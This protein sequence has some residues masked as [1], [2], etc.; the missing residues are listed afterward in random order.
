M[1]N[2]VESKSLLKP[3]NGFPL[4]AIIGAGL[5]G[6]GWAIV[7]ARAGW[8][9][10]LFD[11]D[12]NAI[13]AA[14]SDIQKQLDL[15][16]DFELCENQTRVFGNIS[17]TLNLEEAL[18]DANY[19]QECGPETLEIKK[20]LFHDFEKMVKA[21]CIL[22]SSTSGI[23]ASKFTENLEIRERALVVH[24]TNPPHLVPLVEIAP[25]PWT[26]NEVVSAIYE[27]MLSLGQS[28]IVVNKEI[29]GFVLNR[30][31]GALLNEALRLAEGNYA[32]AED[33]DL[34]VR[35]G[36]GLRWSFMGP[37]ETI[38]LNAPGGLA[39]YA[40]RYGAMYRG[41]SV[42]QSSEATWDKILI[43]RIHGDR[44]AILDDSEL[45]QRQVWRDR[46]L[47][48]LIAHKS[49]QEK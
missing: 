33:I 23:V 6:C 31:Q 13:R 8:H 47:A 48:A 2:R 12:H 29:P 45:A 15:M 43:D 28:P 49:K 25:S 40:E 38:D 35:D 37:F 17:Y 7:F 11:L 5:I 20:N 42:S 16:S 34:A 24:P 46:R 3:Q 36:L 22:A 41:M 18:T 26:S 4:A 19:V 10:R 21:N 32:T 44:R 9:V 1:M 30:L 14:E 27:I 39:D